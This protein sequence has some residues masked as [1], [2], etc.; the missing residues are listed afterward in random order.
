MFEADPR[1]PLRPLYRPPP[2]PRWPPLEVI[3]VAVT[4]IVSLAALYLAPSL[5]GRWRLAEAQADAEAAYLKRQAEL[6]AEAEA[7]DRRLAAL[8]S[9]VKLVSLGFRDVARKVGPAVVNV[10]N[11]RE[12][13]FPPAW[14]QE[15]RRRLFYDYN[16]KR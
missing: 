6:K 15:L 9:K 1:P 16:E 11:E 10:S 13:D 8:D 2:P 7:A 3:F 12:V 5:V 4:L 14:A